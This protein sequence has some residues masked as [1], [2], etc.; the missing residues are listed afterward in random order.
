MNCFAKI[1]LSALVFEAAQAS[2]QSRYHLTDLGTLP[3]TVESAALAINNRGQIAG[4]CV[5]PL[6]SNIT[7]RACNWTNGQIVD[8]STPGQSSFA[9]DINEIGQVVIVAGDS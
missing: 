7:T 3:G 8:L 9:T 4:Y 6:W 5:P 1:V 2:A